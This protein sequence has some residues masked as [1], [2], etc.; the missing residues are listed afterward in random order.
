M[1]KDDYH[2]IVYQ[3]LSYLY[4]QLKK[5]APVDPEYLRHNGHLFEI[6]ESYWIYVMV[7]LQK[8]GLIDGITAKEKRYVDGTPHVSIL[9]LD[10]CQIT[11][12]GI[13]YLSD[14]SF[15]QKAKEFLKDAM[16]MM[17]FSI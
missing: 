2:V 3:I 11:P 16:S 15:L 13:E 4:Q 9:N 7:N 14:N 17:P 5:G 6:P 8:D 10:Q 12:R 1:A